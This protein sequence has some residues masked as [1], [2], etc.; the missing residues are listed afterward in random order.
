MGRGLM[1]YPGGFVVSEPLTG[2]DP[3]GIRRMKQTIVRRAKEGASV[4]VASHLLPLV[5]EICDRV[6]ILKKG[7]CALPGTLDEVGGA[8]SADASLGEVFLGVTAGT[9]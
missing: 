9:A 8:G 3:G 1:A 7:R 2:I 4:I 5:E 6:L